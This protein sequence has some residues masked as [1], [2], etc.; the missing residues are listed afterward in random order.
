[1]QEKSCGVMIVSANAKVIDFVKSLLPQ[2]KFYPVIVTSNAAEAR[3]T[4]RRTPI[5]IIIIDTPLSDEFGTKLAEDLSFEYAV[6]VIVKPELVERTAYKLEPN[7]VITL[8]KMLQKSI[9]LQ[10]LMILASSVSKMRQL[11][12]DNSDLKLKLRE[13]KLVTE[14]KSLLITEMGMTENDAHRYIEKT[15]MDKGLKK[16]DAVK[17]IIEELKNR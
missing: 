15:A 8:S 1:M 7:G 4:L 13:L 17:L 3:R 5:D 14:A 9:L 12:K 2:Y 10:T 16:S 6:A 11:R